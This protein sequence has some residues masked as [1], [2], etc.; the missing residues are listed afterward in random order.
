MLYSLRKGAEG[1]SK[2]PLQK[3]LL[4]DKFTSMKFKHSQLPIENWTRRA[5]QHAE[6]V[7]PFTDAFLKRR[8][9]GLKHAVHDFLFTYYTFSP[10]KLKQWVPS[11][12]ESILISN[13]RRAE[14]PWLNGYWF[15]FKENMLYV[16]R[17][18]FQENT[19]GLAQFVLKLCQNILHRPPRFGCFGLHEWAMV[20]KL[21]PE[22]IR[23]NTYRLR[24]SPEKLATF[25]ESQII[26]CSHYDAYR[27]FTKEARP[28]NIYHPTL[29]GRVQME[30]GGC[31]HANMDLY[32]WSTKLWPWIGSDF[33]AKAFLLAL[34]GRELDMRASPYDL[35]EEGYT[36]IY[37]ETEEGRKQYQKEQHSLAERATVLR[38]E[39]L[40]FC[41]RLLLIKPSR[42][43]LEQGPT[44]ESKLYL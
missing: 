42:E 9:R 38:R 21:S 22:A 19:R 8:S 41:E 20:Y 36:P 30:Q 39:L 29:Q 44:P 40:S 18:R 15:Q 33:I 28:L 32:K 37:I 7:S 25:V 6:L 5:K 12:E 26:C 11:F 34:E 23:H 24:L 10:L 27:F 3:I 2:T 17:E 4:N 16:N 1:I 35:Q 43:S 31:L 13:D 14:Y